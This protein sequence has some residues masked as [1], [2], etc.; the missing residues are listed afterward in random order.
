MIL[1][2][3]SLGLF[4]S[5]HRALHSLDPQKALRQER[6]W[7]YY[8][9]VCQWPDPF[10]Q[11]SAQCHLVQPHTN[12]ALTTSRPQLDSTSPCWGRGRVKLW[13][14]RVEDITTLVSPPWLR[15]LRVSVLCPNRKP[16][17]LDPLKMQ[18]HSIDT[19][20][21]NTRTQ[22]DSSGVYICNSIVNYL[23]YGDYICKS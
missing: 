18:G 2:G 19:S 4:V 16:V 9:T 5:Y 20:R 3:Q 7:C 21:R 14:V 10:Y 1:L 23:R 17:P 15:N 22:T 12:S 8:S 13:Q 6:P 11:P